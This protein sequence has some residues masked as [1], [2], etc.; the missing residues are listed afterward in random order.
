LMIGRII[1]LQR[2]LGALPKFAYAKS[3][4]YGR[5]RPR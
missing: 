3:R 4:A 2:H 5:R 1:A